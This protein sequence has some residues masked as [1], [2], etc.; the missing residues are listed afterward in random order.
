LKSRYNH[1]Q[2]REGDE[3]KTAF[4]TKEGLYEWLVMPFGLTNALSTFM[5]LMNEVLKDFLGIFF[6]I[7]LD[8]ILI[9]TK[10]LEE[11][12]MHIRRVFEKVRGENLL[13]NLKK[14]SFLKRESVCLGFVVSTKGLNMDPEKVKTI[15]EW[16]TP[17]SATEVRYFHGLDSFYRNF[18]KGFSSTCVALTETMR[19]DKKEFKW[20]T[21]V[22]KGFDMLKKKFIEQPILALPYFDKVFQV[23]YDV[24]GNSIG[25]VLSQEGKPIAYFSENLNDA[26]KKSFVYDQEFYAI[27]QA[28]KKWTH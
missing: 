27:A 25:T 17:R 24:S 23:H 21:R 20:T 18:I 14:C 8:D 26:K 15:I 22:A 5:W 3:W 6:I 9:F 13:I 12:L 28:L 19:G 4:K 16:P 11:H 1:I 2:I 7:Y 10:T